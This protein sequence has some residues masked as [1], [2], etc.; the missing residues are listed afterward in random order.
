MY[1][2]PSLSGELLAVKEVTLQESSRGKEAV[3]QIEQEVRASMCAVKWE[4]E[5]SLPRLVCQLKFRL[6]LQSPAFTPPLPT[7]VQVALLSTFNHPNIVRYSGT[8]REGG[9]LFIFLEYVPVRT[10]PDT[11]DLDLGGLI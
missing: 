2:L 1:F 8:L 7:C 9:S 11:A 4:S 5:T 3:A 10:G 6:F